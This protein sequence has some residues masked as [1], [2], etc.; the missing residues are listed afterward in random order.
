MT[1]ADP[2]PSVM[3]LTVNGLSSSVKRQRLA[4]WLK[5]VIQLYAA[6]G[7]SFRERTEEDMPC[8]W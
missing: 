8:K 3:T 7:D 6:V 2:S 1:I 4:E 5:H